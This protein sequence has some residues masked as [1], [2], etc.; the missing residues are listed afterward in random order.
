MSVY[1][2]NIF[3]YL[4]AA[5]LFWYYAENAFGT[6]RPKWVVFL[7]VIGVHTVQCIICCVFAINWLNLIFGL[8]GTFL[9]I[10]LVYEQKWYVAALHAV[11]L[12]AVMAFAEYLV[13][14][15]LSLVF[16]TKFND[17]RENVIFYFFGAIFSKMLNLIFTILLLKFYLT[18]FKKGNPRAQQNG[19]GLLFSLIVPVTSVSVLCLVQYHMLDIK[20]DRQSVIIWLITVALL[21]LS[22]FFVFYYRN[23]LLKQSEEVTNLTLEKQKRQFEEQY[24]AAIEKDNR[25]MQIL[26][27]DFKN[28]LIQLDNAEDME[29]VHEYIQ[30]LYP[31]I[32]SFD[33]ATVSDNATLNVIISKYNTLCTVKGVEFR[34]H[35][36]SALAFL[37]AGDLSAI[38]NNLL[39]NALEAA[40]N[41]ERKVIDLVLFQK[42][43]NLETLIIT[44]SCAY[45]PAEK[46][47]ELVSSKADSKSH[48]FGL[49]SMKKTVAKYNGFYE[50]KYDEEKKEFTTT[51]SFYHERK[52]SN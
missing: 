2:I 33:S 47:G 21:M 51:I 4:F 35:I 14:P 27:H 38:L 26:S 40:E 45:A 36:E 39:D 19:K 1:I 41:S 13:L 25:D 7:S 20:T 28:H 50:W 42:N 43:K 5:W 34:Y 49:K 46:N 18:F 16:N 6:S 9:L 12:Y 15:I 22:T 31:T 10:W 29:Q 11:M 3:I 17:F 44:N 48:G 37:E 8:A 52:R 24:F 23:F 32:R 30:S